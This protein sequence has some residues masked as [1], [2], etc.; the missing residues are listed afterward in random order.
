MLKFFR[1]SYLAQ[2]IVIVVMALVL[3]LPTFITKS[4]ILFGES[5]TPL[6]NIIVSAFS[7]SP[8]LI[9]IV[10]F[11]VFLICVFLFNSVLSANRLVGKYSTVAALSFV[12]MMCVSPELN[13]TFPFVFAC[14]FILM[15]MHTLFLIY[16]TDNPENY[17]MNIGYFIAI[18]S[19]FYYPSVFLMIWVLM[20]FML[21]RF[22]TIRY[23]LIPL[24]GFMIV[25]AIVLGICFLTGSLTDLLASYSLFYKNM[26]FNYDLSDGNMIILLISTVLFVISLSR[27]VSNRNSDK[28]TNIRRRVGAAVILTLISV[29]M[30][31]IQK[32]MM[33]NTLI[34]MMFAFFYAIALSDIRKSR[35]AN[36]VMIVMT[37]IIL[38]NQYLPLFGI[39]I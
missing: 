12:L 4:A 25:N 28:G 36:V 37:V 34:F 10:A 13:M 39:K 30:L 9:D 22:N 29:V 38:V 15:A 21:F 31:F 23:M 3:W 20:S 7:F 26:A 35:I 27:T 33:S 16:Q 1:H 6:Y 24:T 32:P 19:L 14:P 2:Q 8:L 11:A 5:N 17:M 18:A